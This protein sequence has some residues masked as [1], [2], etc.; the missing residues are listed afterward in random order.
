MLDRPARQIRDLDDGDAGGEQHLGGVA[1][2][3]R[4]REHDRLGP[5]LEQV[6]ELPLLLAHGVFRIRDQQV[7]IGQAQ[8]VGEAVG[9]GR[10][11][12]VRERRKH[13]RDESRA[14]ARKAAGGAVRHVAQIRDRFVHAS[15]GLGLNQVEVADHARHRHVGHAG[16]P[17]HL[18]DRRPAAGPGAAIAALVDSFLT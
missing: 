9:D 4:A 8:R 17:R 18:A 15:A 6:L 3:D 13:Q 16:E 1:A 10:K 12:R 5:A 2:V 7:V 14:A 11:V